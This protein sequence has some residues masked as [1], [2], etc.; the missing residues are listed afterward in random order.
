MRFTLA[1]LDNLTLGLMWPLLNPRYSPSRTL[2]A[3]R[4]SETDLILERL[5]QENAQLR[6]ELAAREPDVQVAM[7]ER[8]EIA[9][10]QLH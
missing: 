4:S 6:R 10:H 8:R 3:F 1:L 2:T 7:V 5:H 9:V